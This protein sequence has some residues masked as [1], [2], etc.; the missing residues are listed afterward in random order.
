[1][2]WIAASIALHLGALVLLKMIVMQGRPDAYALSGHRRICCVG[3]AAPS[4]ATG[5]QGI[6]RSGEG[7][8]L[9]F[10]Y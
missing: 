1:M 4:V 10:Q 3:G 9:V 6:T 5:D 8:V 7:V 2:I